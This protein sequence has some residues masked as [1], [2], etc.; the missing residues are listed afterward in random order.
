MGIKENIIHR[1]AF[2]DWNFADYYIDEILD[3]CL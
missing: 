1:I 3:Y 2:K